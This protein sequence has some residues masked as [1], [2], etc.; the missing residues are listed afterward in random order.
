MRE[1]GTVKLSSYIDKQPRKLVVSFVVALFALVGFAAFQLTNAATFVTSA[2]V[3]AGTPV[4]GASDV[5]IADAS[6]GMAVQFGGGMTSPPP[7]PPPG[8]ALSLPLKVSANGRYLVGQNEAPF[9]YIGD[10]AWSMLVSL[11]QQEMT[12][13]MTTRKN[14]GFTVIQAAI[15]FDQNGTPRGTPFSGS[16]SSINQ[17]FFESQVDFAVAK[18]RELGLVLALHPI[19][20]EKNLGL[21]PALNSGNAQGYGQFLGSRYKSD[22]GIIWVMGGDLS[23][24]GTAGVWRTLAKGIAIGQSGTEDY[25]KQLML[26]HPRGN[27]SAGPTFR[28]DA[29][30]DIVASQSGHCPNTQPET[31][32]HVGRDY[33][34]TPVKPVLDYEPLYEDHPYCWEKDPPGF[35]GELEARKMAYWGQFAGGLGNTYGHHSVW[36]FVTGNHPFNV[37]GGGTSGVWTTAISDNGAKHMLHLRKLI[38][39]RPLLSRIPDQSILTGG[40]GGELDRKL[41]ARSSD[42]SYL[43]VYNPGGSIS[44]N[45]NKLS[46]SAIKAYWYDVRTGAATD[47]NVAKGASVSVSPPG[48]GD[49]VFVADDAARGF[50]RPGQ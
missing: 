17:A 43:M 12:N 33:N 42:G 2:E 48:G 1:S 31:Y 36:P 6:A 18:S 13:Y 27:E 23:V 22:T 30:M 34:G 10:T 8:G 24:S 47:V 35:A 50:G 9:T 39:S 20:G 45:L 14:Q 5:A 28:N 11:T 15:Y 29:W 4:G 19:W 26:Y 3:E 41:A 44:V 49:W 32:D 37:W 7:Q 21:N 46:G 38:D 25:S 16:V 40:V